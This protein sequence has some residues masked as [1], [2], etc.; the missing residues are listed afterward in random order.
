MNNELSLKIL[1]S[2]VEIDKMHDDINNRVFNFI[3]KASELVDLSE[4]DYQIEKTLKLNKISLKGF[5]LDSKCCID[6][7][8]N[9]IIDYTI[10]ELKNILSD[11]ENNNGIDYSKYFLAITLYEQIEEIENLVDSKIELEIKELGNIVPDIKNILNVNQS[12]YERLYYNIKTQLDNHAKDNTLDNKSYNICIQILN[13]IF[14]YY[15]G[16]YPNIPD[17]YLYKFE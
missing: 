7:Q 16:G 6:L 2:Y 13:D 4:D 11:Y 12:E 15:I 8:N 1:E 14:N 5:I 9:N 17:E 10:D 3:T